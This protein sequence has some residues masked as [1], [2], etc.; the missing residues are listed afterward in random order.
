MVELGVGYYL[1]QIDFI[2]ILSRLLLVFT[3]WGSS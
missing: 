3:A 1:T 2:R